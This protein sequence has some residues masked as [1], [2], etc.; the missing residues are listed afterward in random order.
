MSCNACIYT[1][2]FVE[3][4]RERDI[5]SQHIAWTDLQSRSIWC[6]R[7]WPTSNKPFSG[8]FGQVIPRHTFPIVFSIYNSL[9]VYVF[10]DVYI[11]IILL[12]LLLYMFH[13]F[14]SY[15]PWFHYVSHLFSCFL[16]RNMSRSRRACGFRRRCPEADFQRSILQSMLG[17]RPQ[18]WG[19][20]E[21]GG[22][23]K[24]TF[25]GNRCIYWIYYIIYYITYHI[26]ICM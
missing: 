17:Q 24:Q 19:R 18:T 21:M 22:E 1:Y 3:R 10:L 2:I 15:F 23:M 14:S 5:P 20:G 4:E 26:Y 8:D 7:E 6:T 16:S 25:L 12:L 11:Y 9:F 13:Q